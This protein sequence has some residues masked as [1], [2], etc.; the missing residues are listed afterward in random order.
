MKL[1]LKFMIFATLLAGLSVTAKAED[2]SG[3]VV[4]SRGVVVAVATNGE[5]REIKQGDFIYVSDEIVTSNRSFAVVQFEDGAKVTV[6]PNTTL[7]IESYLYNGD[8]DDEATL[9]LVEGGLRVITGAL[10]KT[11]PDKYKVRTP[12]ALMGVRGT[13]FSVM[14]CGDELCGEDEMVGQNL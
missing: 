10:A 6:R 1:P 11:N 12:V 4:A 2:S 3:M 9:N 14:L 13:E 5:S 8:G 7:I